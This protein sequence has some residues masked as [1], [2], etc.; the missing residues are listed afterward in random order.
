M[1]LSEVIKP[2]ASKMQVRET[3]AAIVAGPSR[4]SCGS[5]EV[6]VQAGLLNL[7]FGSCAI[8]RLITRAYPITLSFQFGAMEFE[9]RSV[10][11]ETVMVR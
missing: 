8:P 10:A 7:R 5:C 4:A 9:L 11:V 1:Y 6:T 3:C 2:P